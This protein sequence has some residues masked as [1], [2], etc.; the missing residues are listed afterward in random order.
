MPY[1]QNG[2]NRLFEALQCVV[3]KF[4]HPYLDGTKRIFLLFLIS[5]FLT[6]SVKYVKMCGKIAKSL[7]IL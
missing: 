2:I 4:T 1:L 5:S 7:H 6:Y 3:R